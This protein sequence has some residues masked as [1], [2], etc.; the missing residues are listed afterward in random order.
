MKWTKILSLFLA[1][2]LFVGNWSAPQAQI[3]SGQKEA[4]LTLAQ[5]LTGLQTQGVTPETRT[6]TARNQY[7]ARRV[8]ERRVTFS[9]TSEFENELRN[10]GASAE[11]LKAI[12][13]NSPPLPKLTPTPIPPPNPVTPKPTPSFYKWREEV[14]TRA[15]KVVEL[16]QARAAQEHINDAM[17]HYVAF[18]QAGRPSYSPILNATATLKPQVL[19]KVKAFYTDAARRNQVSGK[20][21]LDVV[22]H[23]DGTIG[24]LIDVRQG[25]PD[26]LTDEAIKAARETVFLPALKDGKPVS[27]K[28]TME[29]EFNLTPL[30][31]PVT[32][33]PILDFDK[34][35]EEALTRARKVAKLKQA[36]YAAGEELFERRKRGSLKTGEFEIELS[37]IQKRYDPQINEAT[38]QYVAFLRT[39]YQG[40]P[41]STNASPALRPT[42]LYQEKAKYTE[43][44]RQNRVQGTVIVNVVFTA[45]GRI[46]DARV[47]R[48]LPDGLDEEAIK[49]AREIVFLPALQNGKPVS[50]RMSIEFTFNLI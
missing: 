22:F 42:I 19:Y 20:V 15:R 3:K 21:I 30:P 5:V 39:E 10:A 28:M 7:I 38:F 6:L 37:A 41:I 12:R 29:F 25:L 23:A 36:R 33:T 27:V 44:A 43:A 1:L 45:D 11:L 35:R 8:R 49:A 9:L 46:A 48:S 24:R 13:E 14:I 18:L 16:K 17:T 40:D 2:S 26:G 50:V 34:W 4:P 31:N 47:I 32:S